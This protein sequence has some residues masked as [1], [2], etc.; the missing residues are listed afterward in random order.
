MH[1]EYVKRYAPRNLPAEGESRR[2]HARLV[3]R[4]TEFSGQGFLLPD[5]LDILKKA[6]VSLM[7]AFICID[8]LDESIVKCR[9]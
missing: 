5:I 3:G 6:I 9:Q 8:A 7:L 4:L 2:I 1:H